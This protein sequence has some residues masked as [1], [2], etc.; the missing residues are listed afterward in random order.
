MSLTKEEKELLFELIFN[1]QIKHLIVKDQYG[2][3]KYIALETLKVKLKT[4]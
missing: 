2:T 1:E 4:I 3:N